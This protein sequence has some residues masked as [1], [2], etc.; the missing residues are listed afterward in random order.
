MAG[1]SWDRCEF[2]QDWGKDLQEL[3]AKGVFR[4]RR[5]KHEQAIYG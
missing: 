3:K 5:C 4:G 2:V 1:Y